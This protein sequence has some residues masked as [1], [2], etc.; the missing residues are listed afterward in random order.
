MWHKNRYFAEAVSPSL[1]RFSAP[2]SSRHHRSP[3]SRRVFGQ[4]RGITKGNAPR[5]LNRPHKCKGGLQRCSRLVGR[6]GC[7]DLSTTTRGACGSNSFLN[8]NL[9]WTQSYLSGHPKTGQRWSGQNRPTEEAGD[10]VVLPCSLLWRQVYFRT[11][12]P[13]T[14]FEY[15]SVMQQAV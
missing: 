2:G 14:A 11:P 6:L 4:K 9:E 3:H 15:V 7:C 8:I 13:R 10:S 12:T 5:I 1:V